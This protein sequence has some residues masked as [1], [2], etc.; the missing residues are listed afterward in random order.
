MEISTIVVVDTETTG[1]DPATSAL[2]EVGW[3]PVD[4][5][6]A[7]IEGAADWSFCEYEGEIPAEA[8]A[9][10]HIG[11]KDVARG[12]PRCLPAEVVVGDI[13]RAEVPGEMVYAAHNAAFDRGF[14]PDLTLP[15]ICTFRCA[16]HIWPDAPSHKNQVLRYWLGVE[17]D[18]SLL[19]G[20]D[21]HRAQYDAAV[22]AAILGRMLER[23]SPE[24]L[25]GM[26]SRPV[27]LRRFSFGK[28]KD[29]PV[30]KIPRDY[31]AWMRRSGNWRDDVDVSHTLQHHLGG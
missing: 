3:V 11:P 29:E 30:E 13:L 25:V 20:L 16:R 27:L 18:P 19:V 1:F 31:L 15:F 23:H 26:T 10:H 28:H 5:K 6:G 22:T 4:R 17:P 14:L 9:V 12:A 2:L 8:R 7:P 24:E 21:A